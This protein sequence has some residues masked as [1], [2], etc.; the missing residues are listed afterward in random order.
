MA[1]LPENGVWVD[2]VYQLET[3]DRVL[4]GAGGIANRQAEELG[5]RTAFLKTKTEELEANKQDVG[6]PSETTE[7]LATARTIS[8]SGDATGS[9]SFDGSAD[10]E[11]DVTLPPSGAAAGSYG[12]STT[13][14]LITVDNRG[15]ITNVGQQVFPTPEAQIPAHGQV[16]LQSSTD[17]FSVNLVPYGGGALNI[18]GTQFQ[19]S[20]TISAS[21]SG[22]A[23]NAHYYVYAKE[24]ATPGLLELEILTASTNPHSRD[25]STGIEILTGDPTRVLVGWIYMKFTGFVPPNLVSSWFNRRLRSLSADVIQNTASTTGANLFSSPLEL[26]VWSGEAIIAGSSGWASSPPG[27]MTT[28]TARLTNNTGIIISTY[29]EASGTVVAGGRLPVS[30][31][32]SFADPTGDTLYSWNV[33]GLTSN[34]ADTVTF[35]INLSISAYV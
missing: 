4:G 22:L 19:L 23:L 26:L 3:T 35:R 16:R 32:R 18:N 6:T 31:F 11:I 13:Y 30:M 24:S 21:V 29:A 14:P 5:N 34:A 33:E 25:T 1:N 12:S 10:V 7:R 2:G 9:V 28:A 27:N 17:G 15:I 8:L 20:S